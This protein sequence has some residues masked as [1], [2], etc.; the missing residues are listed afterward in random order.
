MTLVLWPLM[1]GLIHLV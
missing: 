1:G